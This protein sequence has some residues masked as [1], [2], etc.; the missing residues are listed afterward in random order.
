MIPA[1]VELIEHLHLYIRDGKPLFAGTPDRVL[2]FPKQ[3]VTVVTDFK[4]GRL[5][6]PSAD[7]NMQ[8]RAYLCMIPVAEFDDGGVPY[9]YS[10]HFRPSSLLRFKLCPGA[11]AFERQMTVQGLSDPEPTQDSMEGALLHKAIAE[12]LSPRDYLTPEALETVEKA[13]R[14]EK[15]FLDFVLASNSI[16][17]FYGA[18]V[19]PRTSKKA[20]PVSYT[21]DDIGKAL[22]EINGIWDAAHQEGAPRNASA[23]ACRF[24]PAKV[25]CPEYKAWIG[26][27]EKVRHLPVAQWNDEQM[28]EFESRRGEAIRWF[29]HV[30]DQIKSIKAANPERLPGWVLRDG[31][32]VRHI[33]DIPSAWLALSELL[34]AQQFSAACRIALG[35]IEGTLWRIRKDTSGRI[36]QREAKAIVNSKL[37]ALIQLHQNAPSL[38]RKKDA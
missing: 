29:E 1:Y 18:I 31:D 27:I 10:E 22:M 34:N 15:E 21:E 25:L 2:R 24:C 36:T 35:E 11:L 6:V 3:G 33:T 28:D 4:F 12:P 13:E 37:G 20:D 38:V 7:I 14:M 5:E 26:Q 19:Q 23:D 9:G 8:L 30:H 17:P 16:L 32:E